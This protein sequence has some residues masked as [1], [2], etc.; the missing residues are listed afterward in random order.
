MLRGPNEINKIISIKDK[1]VATSSGYGTM[2]E[3]TAKYHH[4]FNPK[5]GKS[6]NNY[7]AVSIVS[8]EAWI[9]DCIS[10]SALLIDAAKIKSICKEFSAKAFI[11][12]NN[13]F[14]ELT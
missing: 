6:A 14:E 3:P 13:N 4:I 7:K 11:V 2:F 8:N 1:A 12:K 9:S 10:T 5:T